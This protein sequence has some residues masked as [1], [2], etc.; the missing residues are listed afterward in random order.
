[1]TVFSKSLADKEV[2]VRVAALKATISFLTSIDDTD[3]VMQ[4]ASVIPKI[5]N[6]VVEALK[7]N[8]DQGRL[9][10]E[11]MQELTNTCPEIWKK[12]TNQLVNVVSQVI[13]QKSFENGTRSAAT[14]VVL[15]LSS[16]MPASLRKI[17]ETRTMLIPA[18]VQ[19]LAEV[20]EDNQI[21]AESIEEKDGAVS[22]TDPHN[23]AINAINCLSN[24]LGEKTIMAPCSGL[25]Q[26]LIKS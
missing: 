13:T 25:I 9:A 3:V 10:L 15:A 23:V 1:M 8:E 16:Q 5:L 12:S 19:M 20:E 7:E 21:W 17:D 6:T 22:S 2:T 26:T 11:S 4:Y 24:D 18:L 14:E